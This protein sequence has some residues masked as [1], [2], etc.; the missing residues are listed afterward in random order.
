MKAQRLRSFVLGRKSIAHDP[1]PHAARSAKLRDLLEKDH[2]RGE[3]ERKTRSEIVYGEACRE[4]GL[5]ISDG[6]AG[7]E[8]GLFRRGRTRLTDV[9]TWAGDGVHVRRLALAG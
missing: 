9:M 5:H 6:V 4:R 8:R 7:G 3:E 1:R 2:V